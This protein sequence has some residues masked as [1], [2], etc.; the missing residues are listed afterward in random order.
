MENSTGKDELPFY[1]KDTP[2]YGCYIYERRDP[3]DDR[4]ICKPLGVNDQE[5]NENT[6]FLLELLNEYANRSLTAEEIEAMGDENA[7]G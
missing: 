6:E 4:M 2:L 1:A 3:E 7:N 5:V